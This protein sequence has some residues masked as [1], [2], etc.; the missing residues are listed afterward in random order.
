MFLSFTC[1][2][3]LNEFLKEIPSVHPM[4]LLT[5]PCVPSDVM[6]LEKFFS[7]SKSSYLCYL[8]PSSN[9]NGYAYVTIQMMMRRFKWRLKISTVYSSER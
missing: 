2:F 6:K 9:F 7:Q 3:R 8:V 1:S 4:V 5:H